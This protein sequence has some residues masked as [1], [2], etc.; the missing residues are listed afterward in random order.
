MTNQPKKYETNQIEEKLLW[1]KS[2]AFHG[3]ECGGLLIGFKASMYAIELLGIEFSP[4]EQLVCISE[5]DACGVDAIQVILG[6]SIGKGN[7]LIHLKGKQAYTFFNRSTG[8]A[9]RLV[10]RE[11]V[12][13]DGA[14]KLEYMKDMLP[15]ELFEVKDAK[16]TVPEIARIFASYPC[17]ICGEMTAEHMLKLSGDQKICP[18]CYVPYRRFR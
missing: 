10:L 9:V 11:T 15:S 18:D 6:C 13:K 3:H 7:L 2:I 14:S 1:E 17:S 5:N 16:E 12:R 4:D 8:K